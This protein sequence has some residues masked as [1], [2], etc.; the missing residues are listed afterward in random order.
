MNHN[1]TGSQI[2]ESWEH[3]SSGDIKLPVLFYKNAV[4]ELVR[5][6]EYWRNRLLSANKH[7]GDTEWNIC[8][9]QMHNINIALEGLRKATQW[10]ETVATKSFK[11]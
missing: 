5:Q 3:F 9:D 11:Q 7:D 1:T 10:G 4:K 6:R 8:N 2:L